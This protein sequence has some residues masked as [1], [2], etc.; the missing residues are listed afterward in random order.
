MASNY[1]DTNEVN[2]IDIE[3]YNYHKEIEVSNFK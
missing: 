2:L 1:Y 3:N